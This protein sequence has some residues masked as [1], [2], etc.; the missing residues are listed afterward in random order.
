MIALPGF[1]CLFVGFSYRIQL[2]MYTL[3]P[4]AG[5]FLLSITPCIS[6]CISVTKSKL[7]AVWNQFWYSLMFLLFVIYPTV[8]VTTLRSFNCQRIGRYGWLLMAD[9]SEACPYQE[10]QL[11]RS[12]KNFVFWWSAAFGI[13]YP[14]GIPL[15]FLLI[16]QHYRVPEIAEAKI[17][18]AKVGAMITQYRLRAMPLEVEILTRQLKLASILP[19]AD[20]L[21]YRIGNLFDAVA[22]DKAVVTSSNLVDYLKNPLLGLPNPDEDVIQEQIKSNYKM[23]FYENVALNVARKAKIVHN[24][25]S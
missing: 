7:D 12:E 20:L 8:S 2:M 1:N 5:I 23:M 6:M 13:L 18:V 14:V 22:Q 9:Y 15:L 4:L 10:G 21:E 3:F 24:M 16:M 17:R 25:A 11:L 19:C